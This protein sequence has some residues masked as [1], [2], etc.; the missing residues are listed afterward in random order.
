ME[1]EEL[2]AEIQRLKALT[3]QREEELYRSEQK[4]VTADNDAIAETLKTISHPLIC[5]FCGMNLTHPPSVGVSHRGC[6]N[7]GYWA[8]G[9]RTHNDWV[10]DCIRNG[11]SVEEFYK[12]ARIEKILISHQEN[13]ETPNK[14]EK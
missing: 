6:F 4:F 8:R 7:T 5:S 3:K 13:G 10:R 9:F 2:K 12:K 1:I 11:A 14:T